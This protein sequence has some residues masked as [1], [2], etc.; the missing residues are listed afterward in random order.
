MPSLGWSSAI[1]N[2]ETSRGLGSVTIP[3]AHPL[4]APQA[5]MTMRRFPGQEGSLVCTGHAQLSGPGVPWW[6]VR[7]GVAQSLRTW[8]IE[9]QAGTTVLFIP[10]CPSLSVPPFYHHLLLST[11]YRAPPIHLGRTLL[12]DRWSSLRLLL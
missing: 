7:P 11:L 5:D 3:G 9:V 4:H 10:L 12:L 8:Q 2:K 6:F 1:I